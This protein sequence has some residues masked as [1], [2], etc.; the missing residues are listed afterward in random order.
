MATLIVK[1][2]RH[3]NHV[4]FQMNAAVVAGKCSEA[5]ADPSLDA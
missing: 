3:A 5:T 1:V 2:K 4:T